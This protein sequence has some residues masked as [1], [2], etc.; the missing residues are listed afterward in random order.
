MAITHATVGRQRTIGG[1]AKAV[2][3]VKNDPEL[4]KRAEEALLRA[5]PG[6]KDG[7]LKPGRPVIVP[8]LPELRQRKHSALPNEAV[9]V[10]RDAAAAFTDQA[11]AP[12][13]AMLKEE[14]DN[15][16]LLKDPKIVAL[17]VAAHSDLGAKLPE[18]A[19]AAANAANAAANVVAG[20]RDAIE[21]IDPSLG[22]VP[23]R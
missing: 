16:A 15:A 11:A 21:R 2:F 6:L 19:A 20:L 12:L 9:R 18:I 1:L 22:V 17:I 8:E 7:G 3:D 13:D 4:Q 14:A 10:V 23:P 5:N